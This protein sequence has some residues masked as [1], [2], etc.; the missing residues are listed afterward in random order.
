MFQIP[1]Y[2]M[3]RLDL[4]QSKTRPNTQ[5]F[6]VFQ[7]KSVFLGLVFVPYVQDYQK[8]NLSIHIYTSPRLVV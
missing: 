5:M 8:K 1:H 6:F 7:M 3:S 2:S 4:S